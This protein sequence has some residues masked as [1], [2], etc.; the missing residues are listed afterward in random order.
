VILLA[1]LGQALD[2]ATYGASFAAT[3]FAELNP[4]IVALGIWAV[5]AKLALVAF[6]VFLGVKVGDR[7]SVRFTL[8]LACAA[9]IC[10]A[11]A[12]VGWLRP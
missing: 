3:D 5:P 1:V 4:L 11:A 10:G 2:F 7:W 8:A 6:L 9:G 12:N